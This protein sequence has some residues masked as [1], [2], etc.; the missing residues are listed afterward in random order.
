MIAVQRPAV[1]V[2]PNPARAAMVGT[3][4]CLL[5]ILGTAWTLLATGWVDGAGGSVVVAMAAVLE[6]AVL[7]YA[8]VPRV[9]AIVLVPI[10]ALAAIIP[11][12]ISALPFDGDQAFLH[13]IARYVSASFIGLSSTQDWAFTVGLCAVLWL[14]AYW[15]TWVALREHRGV[16]AVI[17]I[18][19]VLATNVLN[20]RAGHNPGLP[21]VLTLGFTLLVVANA[22]LDG[23]EARWQR[24]RVLPLPGI[25]SGMVGSTAVIAIGILVLG[26]VLPRATTR[27]ISGQ[28]FTTGGNGSGGKGSGG[29]DSGSGGPPSIG[30]SGITQP[31][32]PLISNPKPVF[33]YTDDGADAPIYLRVINDTQ[34]AAGNWYP[35]RSDEP[36]DNELGFVALTFDAGT[37]PRD[38]Q[39]ADGA[40]AVASEQVTTHILLKPGT[41]PLVQALFPGD[42]LRIDA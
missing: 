21:T 23:L 36:L 29:G 6:A 41:T 16:L 17:P 37:L 35:D 1:E 9:M 8:R 20:A 28:F 13:L 32:G 24:T 14:C 12:T 39:P 5:T 34:F 11:A 26:S 3:G 18:Y 19:I 40:V 25:R 38:S 10:L 30:F 2:V 33:T 22:H 27:D 15:M 42:P 7:A 4:L 31:G